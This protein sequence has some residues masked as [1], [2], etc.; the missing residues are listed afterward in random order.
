MKLVGAELAPP[1]PS[2]E[3]CGSSGQSK[4]GPGKPGPYNCSG[5]KSAA[6]NA[7]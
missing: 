1:A 3:E 4:S 7:P 5:D 6:K 2:D